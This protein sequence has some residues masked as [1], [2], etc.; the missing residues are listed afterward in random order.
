M[1]FLYSFFT[2][3]T[4]V[5]MQISQQDIETIIRYYSFQNLFIDFSIGRECL[6]P[7]KSHHVNAWVDLERQNFVK[8]IIS[9]F[10]HNASYPTSVSA[11]SVFSPSDPFLTSV[12]CYRNNRAQVQS[13]QFN[14][15]T[16]CQGLEPSTSL[17]VKETLYH[18]TTKLTI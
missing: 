3:L 17:L 9:I 18:Q 10:P 6:M 12:V 8:C 7:T 14:T 15:L 11:K 5:I 13:P 4:I 1:I 16:Q 2:E